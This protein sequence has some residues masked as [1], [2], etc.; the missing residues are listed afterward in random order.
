[1]GSAASA[2]RRAAAAKARRAGVLPWR[3]QYPAT[4]ASLSIAS[5]A[6]R[7]QFAQLAE[8]LFDCVVTREPGSAFEPGDERMERAVLMMR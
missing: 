2:A 1:M 7:E 6:G 5:R 3:P 8:L 4:D